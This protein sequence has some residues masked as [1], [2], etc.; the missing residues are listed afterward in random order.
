MV[1]EDV[2]KFIPS[3]SQNYLEDLSQ[4]AW[5]TILDASRYS[6]LSRSL[7][8]RH[9]DEQNL[10]SSTVC[11]KGRSRGRRLIQRASLDALIE[12]GIG[13]K[14]EDNTAGKDGTASK[15]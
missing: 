13:L 11:L 8:Y 1:L 14:S 2:G 10:I 7:L 9:L 4:P 15:N 12:Q 6:G 3:M 5:L